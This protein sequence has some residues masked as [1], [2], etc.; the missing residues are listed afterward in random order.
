MSSYGSSHSYL[1]PSQYAPP[2]GPPPQHQQPPY[3]TTPGTAPTS[4]PQ[5]F[6][7]PA[8]QQQQYF[9]TSA[10]QPMY[11]T[12]PSSQYATPMYPSSPTFQ[13]QHQPQMPTSPVQRTRRSSS[14]SQSRPYFPQHQHQQQSASIPIPITRPDMYTPQHYGSQG[15][16]YSQ[17][18]VPQ[19]PWELDEETLRSYEK[20]Y[21]KDRK[22]EKRPTLGDSLMSVARAIG[23]RRD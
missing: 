18:E 10:A 8:P 3:P 15:S 16:Q 4:Q 23:G 19:A 21:A 7:P 20:R 13:P 22:R 5:G 6:Y 12:S 9:P 2:P 17:E 1:H 14:M 11:S